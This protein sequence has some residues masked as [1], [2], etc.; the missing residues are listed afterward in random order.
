LL[1]GIAKIGDFKSVGRIGL[2]TIVWFT[3]ATLVALTIGLLIAN[4]FEPGK[5]LSTT[6]AS[7]SSLEP[8]AFDLKEFVSHIFPESVVDVMARNQILPIIIFV[9]FFA[10]ARQPSEIKEK[11]SSGFDSVSHVM[12]KVTSYVMKLAPVA[13][14]GAIASVIASKGLGILGGYLNVIFCFFAGLVVLFSDFVFGLCCS[15]NKICKTF[16]SCE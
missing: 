4:I 7:A 3:F 5:H 8:K 13:V 1:T 9:L 15:E 6:I 12:L 2:K 14:F 11:S 10:V 16:K